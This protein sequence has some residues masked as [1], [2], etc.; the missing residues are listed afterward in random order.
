MEAQC[1][2]GA[3]SA[4]WATGGGAG[5]VCDGEAASDIGVSLAEGG[6]MT[7]RDALQQLVTALE[8]Y[9]AAKGRGDTQWVEAFN[10]LLSAL[11]AAKAALGQA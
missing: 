5:A 9:F 1:R 3:V 2:P 7:D 8:R 4:L 10:K 6:G 11:Q